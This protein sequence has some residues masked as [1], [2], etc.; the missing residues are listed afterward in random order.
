VD[1]A[2]H[3]LNASGYL[4]AVEAL[5]EPLGRL[6]GACRR[7]EILLVVTADHGMV[8]PDP[9]GKG[10]HSAEKYAARLEALR[11]PL[12]ITGPGI[13]ELNLGGLWSEVDVAP[14][15]LSLLEI[16]S[17]ESTE[18]LSLPIRAGSTLRVRGAPAGLELW[19]DGIHL[20]TAS[21]DEEEL[22]QG[23]VRG[24]YTLKG[25]GLSMRLLVDGERSVDLTGEKALPEGV[26]RG[27]GVAMIL[28]INL[29]GTAAIVRIWRREE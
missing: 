15:A 4:K 21:G 26:R 22:F 1:S 17:N 28:V 3:N 16:S 9:K 13:E 12:V 19:R 7:N 10:G 20:A 25:E 14:T 24:E 6:A 18:G 23:L 27:M 5:D 11:V 8:F 2:G 29:A